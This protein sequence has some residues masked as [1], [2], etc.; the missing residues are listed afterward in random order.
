MLM[1]HNRKIIVRTIAL[2]FAVCSFV[3]LSPSFVNVPVQ[4][5]HNYIKFPQSVF[6]QTGGKSE[7]SPGNIVGKGRIDSVIYTVSGR[8]NA[9]GNW[10]IVLSDG[11]LK[12][13]NTDMVWNNGTA[14]H[15]HEFRNFDA[16]THHVEI[17]PDGTVKIKGEMDV[18]T[19]HLITWQKVPAEIDLEKGKIITISLDD[20]KTNHHF[21]DQ[22]I[23]GTVSSLKQCNNTPGPEMQVPT[24]CV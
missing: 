7:T 20:E 17:A 23:H 16:K 2:T 18:G 4:I 13:F 9:I 14:A 19:N 11:V 1:T 22:A 10:N 15:S 21:G 6:A 5:G 3:A 8:W 24:P 12:S